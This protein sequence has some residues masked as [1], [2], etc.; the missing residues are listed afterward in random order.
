[1]A[2]RD[3]T[4]Y[5]LLDDTVI[6]RIKQMDPKSYPEVEH[7]TALIRAQ[8][9]IRRLEKR[10]IYR[11]FPSTPIDAGKVKAGNLFMSMLSLKINY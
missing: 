3:R 4:A 8:D 6:S 11:C 1:M 5:E 9:L 2:D 10:E 7:K